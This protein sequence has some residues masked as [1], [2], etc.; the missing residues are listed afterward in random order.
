MAPSGGCSQPM[1]GQNREQGLAL[2]PLLGAILKD[3][4][5]YTDSSCEIAVQGMRPL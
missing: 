3:D 4:S 5:S 1:T 2:L